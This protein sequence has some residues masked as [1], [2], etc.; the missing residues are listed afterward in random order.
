MKLWITVDPA[1]DR[2][3]DCKWQTFG[4]ASAIASTSMMSVMVSEN[5]GM[6]TDETHATHPRYDYGTTRRASETEKSTAAFLGDK[7]Y[8]AIN[9]YYRQSGQLKPHEVGKHQGH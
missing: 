3:T 7:V 4:C 5:G 1:T 6:T 9:D 2:I 8:K